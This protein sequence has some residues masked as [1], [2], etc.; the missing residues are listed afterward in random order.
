M[1]TYYNPAGL[2]DFS[3]DGVGAMSPELWGKFMNYYGSVFQDGAL[4]SR[5]KSLIALAVAA[6]ALA[7]AGIRAATGAAPTRTLVRAAAFTATA[8][9]LATAGI[10]AAARATA[11]ST[12]IRAAADTA[13]D[14]HGIGDGGFRPEKKAGRNDKGAADYFLQELTS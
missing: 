10:G 8:T 3:S 6:A 5:E 7:R 12:L 13:T 11:A 1:E 9:A 14:A 2:A 4:T